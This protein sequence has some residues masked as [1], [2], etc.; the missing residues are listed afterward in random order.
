LVKVAVT[1]H[2]VAAT[3]TATF[4]K[5]ELAGNVQRTTSPTQARAY[6][7]GGYVDEPIA[8]IT[9]AGTYYYH[10]NHLY[11]V[12]ALTDNSGNVVER[13]RYDAYGQRTVLAA[14]GVTVR[15]GSSYGNQYGF[16]GRY[17]DK[18]TGLWYFRARYY[19]G[20]LG[21]F[22]SRDPLGYVDGMSLYAGYYAPNHLDPYGEEKKLCGKLEVKYGEKQDMGGNNK[23]Y[24]I[25]VDVS[26]EPTSDGPT[27]CCCEEIVFIQTV[28]VLGRKGGINERDITTPMSRYNAR[29][30]G[31]AGRSSGWGIDGYDDAG[32]AFFGYKADGNPGENTKPGACVPGK[33]VK[34]TM[35]DKPK[36]NRPTAAFEFE[37]CAVCKKGNGKGVIFGCITWG[38]SV[39]KGKITAADPGSPTPEPTTPLGP[40]IDLWNKQSAR[41]PDQGAPIPPGDS[42]VPRNLGE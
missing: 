32:S 31:G 28:R 7:Y 26:Y 20:S 8:M 4:T 9:P 38:F 29:R 22:V 2:N 23:D 37:T 36:W 19:S 39:S 33:K 24:S 40:A 35:H 18:E 14:D 17:L 10:A 15:A 13:Y 12:A 25:E 3:S 27:C 5:V 34:A 16:T 30:T 6:V 42:W 41:N 1:S 21:R 11:S